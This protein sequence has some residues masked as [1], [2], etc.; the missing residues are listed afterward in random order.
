MA[1]QTGTWRQAF[2]TQHVPPPGAVLA[3]PTL[4]MDVN[5]CACF[6]PGCV[7]VTAPATP[8]FGAQ[9]TPRPHP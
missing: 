1:A 7:P 4:P 5:A 2:H 8:V 3:S 9:R 6:Q